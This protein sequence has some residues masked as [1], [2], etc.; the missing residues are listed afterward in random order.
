MDKILEK[1]DEEAKEIVKGFSNKEMERLDAIIAMHIMICNINDEGAYMT[2]IYLVPDEATEWDFIDF[3]KNDDG[4][5]ENA[6][7]N[8]VDDRITFVKSDLFTN[9]NKEMKFDII[10]SN[11]PYIKTKVIEKLDRQVKNEP[12]IALDG[13]A[14]GLKFYKIIIENS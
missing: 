4:T 13:G 8:E 7:L 12:Y 6:I 14:D 11:P 9:I 1:W 3:A 10:V 5:T 2:W